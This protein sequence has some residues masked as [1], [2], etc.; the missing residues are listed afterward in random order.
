MKI[1]KCWS[2]RWSQGCI[3]TSTNFALIR[4]IKS[5][6]KP[7][8]LEND[9]GEAQVTTVWS[10]W[11][12]SVEF[13]V[14]PS[15]TMGPQ[16]GEDAVPCSHH[17]CL[18]AVGCLPQGRDTPY[19]QELTSPNNCVL[20]SISKDAS[21]LSTGEL[22]GIIEFVELFFNFVATNSVE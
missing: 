12:G 4:L 20:N 17:K 6:A 3:H 15:T 2:G 1:F 19:S 9:V 22:M 18:P 10:H 5:F 8:H 16:L 13:A 21:F 14:P 11:R 7:M